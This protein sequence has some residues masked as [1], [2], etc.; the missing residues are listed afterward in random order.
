MRRFAWPIIVISIALALASLY[1]TSRNLQFR[2]SRNDLVAGDQGLIT[3]SEKLEKAF[4]SHDDLVVVVENGHP[5]SIAF[6]EALAAEVRRYPKEFPE[7]FYRLDPEQFKHWALLYPDL[8]DLEKLKSNL[9][10]NRRAME[11]LAARPNLSGYFQVINE[12]ITRSM[13]GQLFTGFLE[14]DQGEKKLPDLSFLNATLREFTRQLT[15]EGTYVSPFKSL[16]PGD[17]ADLSQEG[18]LFTENDKYLLFL[19]TI[20]AD[21]FATKS[22]VLALVRQLVAKVQARYPHIKAGVTGPGALEADE[23]AGALKEI[24]LATWLSLLGQLILLIIFMR[25]LKR[26]L[27]QCLI[28]VVGLCWTVGVATLVV[29]HLNLLS[30]VFA[31]LMLGITIDYGVHWFARLE[32]EQE[33]HGRCTLEAV[34]CALR[35]AAPGIIYVAVAAAV[36]F[37]PLIF[38]GFKGL[39]ELGQ[40][41]SLGMLL[42]LVPSLVFL[43]ALVLVGERVKPAAAPH[44]PG[45]PRPFLALA[46][47]R[48]GM[49]VALGLG[50]MALGGF[51]LYHVSYDLNPLHLQNQGTESV[52]W[53]MK[54]LK[55]SRYST[56]YGAM[57]AASLT[58]LEAKTQALKKLPTVSHVE[59]ALSFIPGDVEAK[60]RLFRELDPVVSGIKFPGAP[61]VPS[62]ASDLATVLGR[63]LFK[64]SQAREELEKNGA[65]TTREQV[66]EADSL[67]TRIIPLLDLKRHPQASSRLAAFEL[68]FFQDLQEKWDLLRVNLR[69]APPGLKDL[70]LEVKTRFVSPQGEF[71]I[72]VF[73]A[74]DIWDQKPLDKFVQDLRSVDPEVVGDP[75]LLHHF[76]RAF[77]RACV[78]AAGAALAAIAV[79]LLLLFRS[80]KLTLLALL[81][82]FVGTGLTL[83]IMWL[84]NIPFNQANV[85]FLPLILGEGIEFGIIILVRWRQDESARAITLP[86]STAKGVALAAL[87]TTVG[88]GS[89]MISGHQGVFS[90]GLLATVGSLSVLLAS[91][92]VL[93]AFLRLLGQRASVT[94][95]SFL[96]YT[97]LGRK[98]QYLLRK[99]TP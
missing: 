75:V 40:I 17:L 46:W 33:A 71:L 43:P 91:L 70:P 67:L 4:G 18:Y 38:T 45:R 61:A 22:R 37:L 76:N 49:I 69:A 99:E 26:P 88:F 21:G 2:T 5:E 89:L 30:I 29:G 63:I 42:M 47:K 85:L 90:L 60:R 35:R 15:G 13:I 82:L 10:G 87:T 23:M 73:P 32:E 54:L 6:A 41:L 34:G 36:S 77:S 79:M 93:P 7:F 48:P 19:I 31:P 59:S 16:F 53:E 92:S 81:P 65:A 94:E 50:V 96:Q 56:A 64:L 44:E 20:E 11:G 62:A 80:W 95:L 58:E 83:N 52:V 78:W 3:R 51:S 12:E 72:R 55:D 57:S 97:A 74:L 27:M 9:L 28:L 98:L 14:E 68:R 39:A 84:L 1:Y 86:A 8:K 24:S 25:S 66:R